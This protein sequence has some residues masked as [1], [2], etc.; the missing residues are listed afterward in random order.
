M[1]S[2]E[3]RSALALS[4]IE[5]AVAE[6]SAGRTVILIDDAAPENE[7]TLAMAAEKV[8]PEAINFMAKEGRGIICVSFTE[9]RMRKLAIAP[10]PSDKATTYAAAVGVMIDARKGTTTGIS[11]AD[12]ALTIRTAVSARC[13]PEDLVRPGHV[14]PLCAKRGGVLA[15]TGAAEGSV[16][17]ARLAG[18]APA[19]V[20]CGIMRDDGE[21][22][23][24]QDLS[25]FAKKHSLKIVTIADLVRYRIQKELLVRRFAE[26][27]LPT[28][29]G[30]FRA[31]VYEN[32]LDKH[33]HMA[34]VLGMEGRAFSPGEA[35][36]VRMHS[37]CLTGDV[38]GS[39]KCDCGDQLDSALQ[40][41]REA[42]KGVLVYLRQ[43]GRGIGLVNKILAYKL[44]DAGR[45]TVEANED[46][47]FKADLRDYGVGAQILVDLGARKLRL[48][49]NN[50]KKIV[51]LEGYGLEIVERVPIE[52]DLNEKNIQYL[53]TKKEKLGHLLNI[54][55]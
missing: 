10:Q 54:K 14:P 35:L 52:V 40:Q 1:R 3:D 2:P 46:L 37:E 39:S 18:L 43:E 5:E 25:A 23:R 19:G 42:G 15:R 13:R 53:R 4:S 7:G 30:S 55:R 50:P 9:Q 48:M 34:L 16:D 28:R 31:I 26:A 22:A 36:L 47:G 6:I 17:L 41:I 32:D 49:T 24:L 27:T 44:Q 33:H 51:G 8:T 21:M 20:V 29:H 45:D 38:F 11:A 12:R